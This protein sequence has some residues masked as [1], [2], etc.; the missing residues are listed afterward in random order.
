MKVSAVI[1][2]FNRRDYI[3][4]AIDS[5]MRQTVPVDEIVVV[6]DGSTDGTAELVESRYGGAVR[7]V[8]QANRGVAGAR[9]RGIQEATGDWIAFLD[10]DDEWAPERHQELLQAAQK[11][12]DDVAWIFGDLLFIFDNG[13]S[14]SLFE[15]YGLKVT[16]FPHI[17]EDS[18][19][20]QYPT[21]YSYQQASFIR[22]KALLELN[23]FSEGLRSDDDILAAF[24][25]G[26]KYKFA[27]IP[28]IVGN[29][30]RTSDLA[31]SSVVVNGSFKPDHYRS[32]MMAFAA[33]IKS[34]RKQPWNLYYATET[35]G[36]CM[37]LDSKQPS[38]RKLA[39]EQFRYGGYSLK[40][41]V[42]ACFALAGRP[43][44]K[45]WNSIAA[46]RRQVLRR[47]RDK[48]DSG[49]DRRRNFEA[50]GEKHWQ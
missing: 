14:G 47:V 27:A 39:F 22:R 41:L 33:A 29:Y 4:R 16:E 7:V 15:A 37:L 2:A 17:F 34:G 35:R 50:I 11:V 28:R 40:G 18:L 19:S 48:D 44:I 1:P 31:A 6:D 23:C 43:G 42:F 9:W 26:C 21:L 30:Y 3:T 38:P 8:R 20:V 5:A 32:R 10:S 45:L 36:L 25:I 46:S 24:Q 12:P 13:E 49:Q